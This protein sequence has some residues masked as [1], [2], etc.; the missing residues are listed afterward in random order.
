M[1]ILQNRQ[2][3]ISPPMSDLIIGLYEDWI[4]LDERIDAI[5]SEIE[6]IRTKKP[7]ASA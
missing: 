7:T 6:K 3:E 2:D 5:A 4:A 1:A